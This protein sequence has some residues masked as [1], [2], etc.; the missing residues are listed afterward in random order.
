MLKVLAFSRNFSCTS[1]SVLQAVSLGTD[2]CKRCIGWFPYHWYHQVLKLCPDDRIRPVKLPVLCFRKTVGFAFFN[3]RI[4][5]KLGNFMINALKT[6]SS[7]WENLW[8]PEIERWK[9]LFGNRFTSMNCSRLTQ[10]TSQLLHC[11][12]GIH[13]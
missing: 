8:F 9:C 6:S 13:H 1:H 4:N 7:C 11:H 12:L 5:V 3:S 10:E 2:V